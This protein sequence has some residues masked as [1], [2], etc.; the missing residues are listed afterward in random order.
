VKP[1][2]WLPFLVVAPRVG[3]TTLCADALTGITGAIVLVPQG[4]AF[5][6]IAGMPPEYGLYAAMLPAVVATLWGS[7]W[8]ARSRQLPNAGVCSGISKGR[9]VGGI[10][11][12]W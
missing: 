12:S 1:S 9:S 6:S 10:R 11:N 7:S 4:V 8:L 3:A 5:A 2:T